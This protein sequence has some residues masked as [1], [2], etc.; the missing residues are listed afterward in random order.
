VTTP[1]YSINAGT[2]LHGI[3]AAWENVPVQPLDSGRVT[4]SPW[5][6]H[7]WQADKMPVARWLELRA[8]LGAAVTTLETND[9]D[10]P[11]EAQTYDTAILEGLTGRHVGHL[12]RE[13]VAEFRVDETSGTIANTGGFD[14][15]FSLG[16]E[17]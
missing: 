3:T 13:V 2:A 16:F 14:S 8:A 10:Y 15:G 9:Y 1:S 12:V 17:T 7:V 6:R 4:F 5:K 11:N